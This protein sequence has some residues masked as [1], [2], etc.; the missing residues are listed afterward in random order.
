MKRRIFILVTLIGLGNLSEGM[1]QSV[2]NIT[3]GVSIGPTQNEP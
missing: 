3:P 2:E 1:A